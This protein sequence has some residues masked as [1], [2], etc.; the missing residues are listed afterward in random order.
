MRPAPSIARS[1]VL[2]AAW[3][4][5]AT[6]AGLPASA[7]AWA[8]G[9]PP[10]LD[11]GGG[12]PGAVPQSMP[13]GKPPPLPPGSD[14]FAGG[15]AQGARRQVSSGTGFV[16]APGRLLTNWHVA[17]GCAEM[18][19]RTPRGAELPATVAARD[20]ERDLALLSVAGDLGPPLP[21]RA[22]PEVRRGEGVV[23]YGFPLAGMLSSGA[24]LTT[25]DVSALSGLRDNPRH[26]QISAPVQSGNS[27]GPL[28]DMSG[29]VVGV[30]VS[31]LNAQRIAQVTGDLPQNVN[32][33]VK[34][35]EA[36][37]FLQRNGVRPALGSTRGGL[38]P[39]DVGEVAEPS[40]V[41]LRCLR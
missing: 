11:G 14:P 6:A 18:R 26:Y 29:R 33:A 23:T 21:F 28:L 19:A 5:L 15:G 25:G 22:A 40:T 9:K 39:A 10:P 27:G 36:L 3:A 1:L 20:P 4:G 24:T 31:K 7:P 2:L 37:E 13:T 38:T 17:E 12:K 32:F 41:L 30:V 16:V 35:S 34:G 8:Q